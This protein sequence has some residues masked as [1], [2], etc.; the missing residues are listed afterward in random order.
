M[1]IN[2]IFFSFLSFL[3]DTA[4][5]KVSF[6]GPHSPV[7]RILGSVF[8]F[9]NA[10]FLLSLQKN[11]SQG[12]NPPAVKPPAASPAPLSS[13]NP[14]TG[15]KS[16]QHFWGA[17]GGGEGGAPSSGRR[18]RLARGPRPR[19]PGARSRPPPAPRR[20][21]RRPLLSPSRSLLPLLVLE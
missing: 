21:S 20:G 5:L 6:P 16:L 15:C 11:Q 10:A 17:E 14:R 18:R 8:N 9:G 7:L 4:A 1:V 12:V 13:R 19:A 2:R 3:K